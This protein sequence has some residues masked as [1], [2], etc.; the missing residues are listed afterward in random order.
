MHKEPTDNELIDA[1]GGTSATAHFFG[2]KPPSVSEWRRTGI[3][4]LQKR[5]LRLVRPDLF[6]ES[7]NTVREE[8]GL[9]EGTPIDG[10]KVRE[11]KGKFRTPKIDTR[12]LRE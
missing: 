10:K 12:K 9:I 7:P 1:L 6:G 3:P 5:H 8:D 4:P 11:A 2:I